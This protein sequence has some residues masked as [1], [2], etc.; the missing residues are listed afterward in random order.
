MHIIF[1]PLPD[2]SECRPHQFWRHFVP[3][4]RRVSQRRAKWRAFGAAP[5]P[6]TRYGKA[7]NNVHH[8]SHGRGASV[9]LT[10]TS[11]SRAPGGARGGRQHGLLWPCCGVG[12]RRMPQCSG[13]QT[14]P[15]GLAFLCVP[16]GPVAT[17]SRVAVARVALLIGGRGRRLL[18]PAPRAPGPVGALRCLC[19]SPKAG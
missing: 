16:S 1:G 7:P 14:A 3:R 9:A 17:L 13:R 11:A 4:V 5:D 8:A 12:A 15:R 18:P 19:V 6:L 10:I 2:R